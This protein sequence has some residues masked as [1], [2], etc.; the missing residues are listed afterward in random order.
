MEKQDFIYNGMQYYAGTVVKIKEDKAL[1][2]Q[3][4][5]M[6]SGYEISL[7][8]QKLNIPRDLAEQ[9]FNVDTFTLPEL[10]DALIKLK[11]QFDSKDMLKE[12]DKLMKR[13][14]DIEVKATRER[15]KTYTKYLLKAQSERVKIK[16]EELRQIE[17]IEKENAYSDAQK[18][19]IKQGIKQETQKKLDK[20]AWE[21]FKDSDLYVQMFDEL[22][23]ASTKSLESMRN[24]LNLLR[25]S[26][27]N[28][29]ASELKEIQS[30]LIEINNELISR[31]PFKDLGSTINNGIKALK[32][33]TEQQDRY[34]QASADEESA[35]ELVDN[36][37][38]QVAKTREKNAEIKKTGAFNAGILA[39]LDNELKVQ[40]EQLSVAIKQYATAKGITEEEAKKLLFQ[41]QAVSNATKTIN[42][43]GEYGSEVIDMITSITD[44]LATFGVNLGAEFEIALGGIGEVFNSLMSINLQ[45]PLSIA[46]GAIGAISG[47][48]SAIAEVHDVKIERQINRELELLENLGNAYE[49]LEE[50]MDRAFSLSTLHSNTQEAMN[51]LKSQ[52]HSY[53]RMIKLEKDK[54]KTDTDS[55][56][57]YEEAIDDLKAKQRELEKEAVSSATSGILDST[58]DA[59]RQ[60]VDAWYDAFDETGDG[61]QGL[62]DNFKEI[63][64]DMIQ[65]Q[66][67]MSIAGNFLNRWKAQLDK[68]INADDL[69]LTTKEAS[70]WMRSV[71]EELPM[72]NEALQ[73]Y[74]TAM[75]QAGVDLSK[76]GEMSGLQRGIQGLSEDT[77]QALEALL[78][79]TRFFV[80]DSNA[81]LTLLVDSFTNPESANPMLSELRS[82]TDLIR[83]IRDM[84]SSVIGRG[85][86]THSGA[87]LKV[88]M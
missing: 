42:E 52:I 23:Y 61:L 77:A 76:T 68:Y 64:L 66:A 13:I 15:L 33:L 88:V 1:L 46:K 39:Y 58:R 41:K 10:K 81:K 21:E 55:V 22:E 65:Q 40:E 36:L 51:N 56:R 47:V 69:E 24:K 80:A 84:F 34:N 2:D 62:K 79:S 29:D 78:N 53:E 31:N 74:F 16:L 6:F 27:K 50:R 87:Y 49:R 35:K 18:D 11:P 67:S 48:A 86:S 26:L 83:T 73:N 82:Q 20:L 85:D 3:I 59:A 70:N 12:W 30:R 14:D 37:Q 45:D 63:M 9:L 19:A 17:E 43:I 75:E 8:L 44:T 60:F 25:D 71:Q 28:L 38:I 32:G 7:E 54:K 57:Q 5:E 4:E 72:L